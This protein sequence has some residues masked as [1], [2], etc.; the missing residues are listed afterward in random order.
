MSDATSELIE[1]SPKPTKKK[2]DWQ[3]FKGAATIHGI[4]A[5]ALF[6]LWAAADAWYGTTGLMIASMISVIMALVAGSWLASIIHEWGHFAGARLAG[7]YSPI[8]PEV[9]GIFMFGF[10]MEKN[11]R[12]QFLAMSMGGPIANW[13]FVIAIFSFI[14]MDN[15][16]RAA[17]LAMAFAR[18]V[19][20]CIF[21]LPIINNVM[22]GGDPQTEIDTRLEN[23]SQ[24]KGAVFGY[25]SG[26]AVLFLAA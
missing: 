1:T 7:S 21:E 4:A 8:V 9:R 23:G 14:P 11:N 25:L 24:D 17:L 5:L 6:L 10:N 22:N 26:L 15:L 12:N 13:L 16:G 19:S 18:A 2:S 3:R 20:V